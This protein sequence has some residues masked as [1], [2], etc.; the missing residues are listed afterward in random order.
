MFFSELAK[1]KQG[2]QLCICSISCTVLAR[3]FL[4]FSNQH[5]AYRGGNFLDANMGPL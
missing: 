2:I 3:V 4:S 1:D 5:P